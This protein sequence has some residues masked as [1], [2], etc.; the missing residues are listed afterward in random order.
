MIIQIQQKHQ[1]CF[2]VAKQTGMATGS[3][4]VQFAWKRQKFEQDPGW[5][6]GGNADCIAHRSKI[7]YMRMFSGDWS[8]LV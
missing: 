4:S 6:S 1:V 3:S 2:L 7:S 5:R 8:N